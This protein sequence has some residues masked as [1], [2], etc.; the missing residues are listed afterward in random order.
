MA[1]FN[2][3]PSGDGR[4]PLLIACSGENLPANVWLSSSSDELAT[5]KL[6]AYLEPFGLSNFASGVLAC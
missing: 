2:E 5:I 3:Y 6:G 1:P 4:S